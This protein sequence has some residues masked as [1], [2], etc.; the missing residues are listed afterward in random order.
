MRPCRSITPSKLRKMREGRNGGKLKS[1]N[2]GKGGRPRKLP[3]LD[4]LLA[5]VMGEEKDGLSAAEAILKALRAKATKGDIRAAE[6]LLDRAYGKAK[7]TIDNNLNVSQPLVITL[8]ASNDE[9]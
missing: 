1:G 7:Q 3:E 6:V 8:T 5:D 2:D 4:K 9:E